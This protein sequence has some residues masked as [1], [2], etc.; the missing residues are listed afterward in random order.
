MIK[1]EIK[2]VD[3]V[4][5]VL[6]RLGKQS[7]SVS[8]RALNNLGF[9]I[10]KSLQKEME[11][12]FANPTP[13]TKRSIYVHKATETNP[14][15]TVDFKDEAFKAIPPD[16]YMR[17]QVYGGSR[18]LKRSERR[19]G[20]YAYPGRGAELDAYGNMS[21]GEIVKILTQLGRLG[22]NTMSKRA[23]KAGIAQKII[24]RHLGTQ[25]F[26]AR[27]KSNGKPLGV[28]KLLG[29]GRV[30]PVLA[31]GRKP[32]YKPR[33]DFHGV[34]QRVIEER[35]ERELVRALKYELGK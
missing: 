18:V 1:L 10:R 2:G 22:V 35:M 21:R 20:T 5:R 12:A 23:R 28:W 30:T 29:T 32:N 31:F 9:G 3:N 8:A 26:V 14:T 4:T 13:Y 6:N 7:N 16:R 33:F 11:S 34:A 19:L 24:H 15:M 25:Y 17:P 27:S